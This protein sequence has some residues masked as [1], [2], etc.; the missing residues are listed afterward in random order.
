[1]EK[2]LQQAVKVLKQGGIVVF[3]T[4]T[5]FGVGCR[6]D[7]EQAVK[8]LFE[9]RRRPKEKATP[10]LVE[11]QQMAEEYV[12][13]VPQEVKTEL[14]DKYWPGALTIVLQARVEKVPDLVR[15]GGKNLG[16]RMP[17]HQIALEIIS[18]V[19]V[20]ILGPSANFSGEQT[21]YSFE[22]L[23]AEFIRNVDYIVEG[24]CTIKQAS[25]VIDCTV[26]PWKVLREGGIT[27]GI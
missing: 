8:K 11:N 20:P 25:T 24:K 19:G 7:N 23:D 15:G 13:D 9:I 5:A 4:D 16:V 18:G 21:P 27:L 22:D 14:I 2:Q 12:L 6:I 1:M 17:N 3:P 26:T 10:V